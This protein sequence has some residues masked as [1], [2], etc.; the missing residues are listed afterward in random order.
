MH[1]QFPISDRNLIKKYK[2]TYL[3][4]SLPGLKILQENLEGFIQSNDR[5]ERS[6]LARIQAL[7]E[8]QTERL[9]QG[10]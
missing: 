1:N 2:K 5:N 10:E 9:L 7:K 3:Q 4:Y 6:R 8:L